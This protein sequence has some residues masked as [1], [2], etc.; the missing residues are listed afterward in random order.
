[1]FSYADLLAVASSAERGSA[2]VREA[3]CA[4][5]VLERDG[6]LHGAIGPEQGRHWATEAAVAAREWETV[7]LM[8]AG[9]DAGER[10][11]QRWMATTKLNLSKRIP[12]EDLD[13][14]S[15]LFWALA[16]YAESV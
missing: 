6:K 4:I 5:E 8:R 3:E 15:D 2:T 16:K 11:M 14:S 1:M 12:P 9:K 10:I 7:G 13:E